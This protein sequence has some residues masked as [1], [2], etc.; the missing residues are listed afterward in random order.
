M[1]TLAQPAFT[2]ALVPTSH[3]GPAIGPACL[4]RGRLGGARRHALPLA[5]AD[6]TV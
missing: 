5:Q 1:S 4:S 2:A 3:R 6:V